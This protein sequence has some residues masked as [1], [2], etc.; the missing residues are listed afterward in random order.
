MQH[1]EIGYGLGWK[2]RQRFWKRFQFFG[3]FVLVRK[4]P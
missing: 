1:H 2:V 3:A 4:Q